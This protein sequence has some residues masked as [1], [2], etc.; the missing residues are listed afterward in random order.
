M[1]WREQVATYDSPE[2]AVREDPPDAQAPPGGRRADLGERHG[3]QALGPPPGARSAPAGSPGA[4]TP[5][6]SSSPS[7][8]CGRWSRPPA[9]T[10]TS[11]WSATPCRCATPRAPSTWRPP[12]G[13][14]A[15]M[16]EA[17]VTDVRVGGRAR[18]RVLRRQPRHLPG[19]RQ[20]VPGRAALEHPA[21][22]GP[23]AG[24]S[25]GS[26]VVEL[27]HPEPFARSLARPLDL[28]RPA[29]LSLETA[30][31]PV[32][33]PTRPTASRCSA[34]SSSST[35]CRPRRRP[36]SGS[37]AATCCGS[38]A[39]RSPG[40]RCAATPAPAHYD[41]VDLAPHLLAGRER[42]RHHRP[43][44]RHGHVVVDAGARRPTRWAPASLVFEA[45]I[46]DDWVVTDRSW[47]RRRG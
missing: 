46:G 38:T 31:R 14:A 40:A 26:D 11:A 33:T 1:L 22:Q 3:Q 29:R 44:L 43:P 39:S 18:R 4:P 17:G 20:G 35:R 8:P 41:V 2:L 13:G 27:E 5:A 30:T 42:D 16:V 25:R 45:L 9:A 15:P 6:T 21:E 19:H 32:L 10:P 36:G 7:P 34:G 23:G 28:G 12:S 37:T 47:R 24:R